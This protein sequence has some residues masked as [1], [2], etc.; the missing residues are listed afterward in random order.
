MGFTRNYKRNWSHLLCG[1]GKK[2]RSQ[3]YC[4]CNFFPKEKKTCVM[5]V[6]E[7]L[8]KIQA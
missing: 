5:E 3:Y 1:G 6:V 8:L 7:E 4:L 2:E